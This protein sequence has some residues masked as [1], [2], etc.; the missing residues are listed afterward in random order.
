VSNLK[1]EI[2][3]II[4]NYYVQYKTLLLRKQAKNCYWQPLKAEIASIYLLTLNFYV[5]FFHSKITLL[6]SHYAYTK[7]IYIYYSFS[8]VQE[9][10]PT[11]IVVNIEAFE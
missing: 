9:S 2:T 1:Q 5:N 6:C 10:R 7:H 11:G 8:I 3:G 4:N